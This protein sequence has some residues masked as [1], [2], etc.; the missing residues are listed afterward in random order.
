MSDNGK[1]AGYG[2][3]FHI[4]LGLLILGLIVRFIT[5]KEDLWISFLG[6]LGFLIIVW[7]MNTY[8]KN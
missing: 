3:L 1:K 8:N 7:F 6:F 4:L 2:I 5:D